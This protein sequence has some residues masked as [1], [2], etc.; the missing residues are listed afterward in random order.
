[1]IWQL[2]KI[3]SH[4]S[5]WWWLLKWKLR[6]LIF[7]KN[8]FF[9]KLPFYPVKLKRPEIPPSTARK[10][11]SQPTY[12][13]KQCQFLSQSPCLSNIC[14]WIFFVF[15]EHC[16]LFKVQWQHLWFRK[17]FGRDTKIFESHFTWHC[18]QMF[19]DF[20]NVFGFL[21]FY[22]HFQE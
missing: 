11:E 16:C 22:P 8:L 1:M 3:P 10:N 19:E 18:S 17:T 7:E 4:P 9:E 20:Q 5:I 12:T 13:C 21:G 15:S 14:A 6:K 2:W